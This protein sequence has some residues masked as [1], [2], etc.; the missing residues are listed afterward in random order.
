M[1]I[2]QYISVKYEQKLRHYITVKQ[3]HE[4][5]QY[6]SARHY[7]YGKIWN[8]WHKTEQGG[9]LSSVAYAPQRCNRRKQASSISISYEN[10][11]MTLAS[12]SQY[13]IAKSYVTLLHLHIA[14][15]FVIILQE[16]TTKSF[17]NILQE[18][19]GNTSIYYRKMS[20]GI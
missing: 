10:I 2:C 4:S 3:R 18:Q 16:S 20:V 13:D 5:R 15:S 1:I 9:G 12:I 11:P 6:I 19:K 8:V 14:R 7:Q 17:P